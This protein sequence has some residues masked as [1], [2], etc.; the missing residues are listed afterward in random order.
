MAT[1]VQ[2]Q[3]LINARAL[4][5]DPAHWTMW[6][7]ACTEKGRPVTW[8]DPSARRWC[9]VG[10]IHRAAYDLVGDRRQAMRIANEVVNNVYPHAWYR[11]GLPA[12][13]DSQGHTA[14]LGL[15]DKA[16]AAA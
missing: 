2:K 6:M 12:V 7:L 5:A 8:H 1:T 11:R 15:F 16:L 10:A 14:V 4:I 9:A 13:N 3:V